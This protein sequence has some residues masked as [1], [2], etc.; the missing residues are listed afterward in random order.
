[1]RVTALIIVRLLWSFNQ[2]NRTIIQAVTR[3]LV[4]PVLVTFKAA[5]CTFEI[6]FVVEYQDVY[7]FSP[8]FIDFQ[9]SQ[10]LYHQPNGKFYAND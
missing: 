4:K 3:I 5:N 10:N 9:P 6:L 8:E 1:M 2:S 7:E